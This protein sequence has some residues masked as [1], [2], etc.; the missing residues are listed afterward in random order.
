MLE[1]LI[2]KLHVENNLYNHYKAMDYFYNK[3]IENSNV[4]TMFSAFFDLPKIQK[5]YI[6]SSA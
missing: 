3:I 4:L 2:M 6:Q 1:F 5:K